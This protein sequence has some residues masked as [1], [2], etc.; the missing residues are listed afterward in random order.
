MIKQT[1]TY[2]RKALIKLD[3]LSCNPKGNG[4]PGLKTIN[5]TSKGGSAEKVLQAQEWN[6]IEAK[7]Q[8][9]K[10]SE[11]LKWHNP[12]LFYVSIKT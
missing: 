7:T 10:N 3:S 1:P 8:L 9:N 5:D 6:I 4:D 12:I 11:R 2:Q